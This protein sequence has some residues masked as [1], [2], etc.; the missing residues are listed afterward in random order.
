MQAEFPFYSF[1][2]KGLLNSQPDNITGH[3]S[4]QK[5]KLFNVIYNI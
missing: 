1:N 2:E 4:G 5:L 3:Q